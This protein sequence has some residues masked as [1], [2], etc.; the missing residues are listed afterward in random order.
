MCR[1]TI[2][3]VSQLKIRRGTEDNKKITFSHFS[4]KT[5]GVFDD[6]FS[7]SSWKPYVETPHL[8]R[9]VETVQMRGHNICF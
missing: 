2:G 4:I 9:L 6:N 8:N 7:Y 5:C 3:G 1:K